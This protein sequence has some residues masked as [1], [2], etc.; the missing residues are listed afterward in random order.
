MKELT[1]HEASNLWYGEPLTMDQMSMVG[2]V[3]IANHRG[4]FKK[5][6]YW[7]CSLTIGQGK[8][9]L[10]LRETAPTVD[11]A[12]AAVSDGLWNYVKGIQDLVE[13]TAK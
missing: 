13:K 4:I 10:R 2:S 6:H 3:L 1:V 11:G 5:E 12:L 9:E 8:A 7:S